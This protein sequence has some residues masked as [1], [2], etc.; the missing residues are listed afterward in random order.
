[1]PVDLEALCYK[2]DPFG[3]CFFEFEIWRASF[4]RSEQLSRL[5]KEPIFIMIFM[6]IFYPFALIGIDIDVIV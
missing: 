5:I 1:M 2:V 6:P 3:M 4:A